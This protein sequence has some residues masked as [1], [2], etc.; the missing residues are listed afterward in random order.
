LNANHGEK[1]EVRESNNLMGRTMQARRTR[2]RSI[3]AYLRDPSLV[4]GVFPEEYYPIETKFG[5]T[6]QLFPRLG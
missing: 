3:G 5:G 2:T 4:H 1:V 6:F